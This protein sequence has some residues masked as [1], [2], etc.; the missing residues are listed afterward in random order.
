LLLKGHET[1]KKQLELIPLFNK[2][3]TE[4]ERGKRLQKDGSRIR[5]RSIKMY[6][7]VVRTLQEFSVSNQFPL[8]VLSG[9]NQGKRE[10]K[11]ERIYWKRFYLSYTNFLYQKGCFDNY[12]GTHIKIIRCFFNYLKLEK[13]IHT[14]EFHKSFYVRHETIPVVVLSPEQL[15]FLINDKGFEES[16]PNHLQR[17]K[18]LF[19][20]GCTVGL[21]FSD[22]MNLTARNLEYLAD[23]I[24][25]CVR[26]LKTS[27]ETRIKIPKY[28]IEILEKYK[29]KRSL[30]PKI[31]N[32][33]L[34]KNLKKLGEL[35][36]WVQEVN[37]FR[38]QR[39]VIKQLS[40]GQSHYRFCDLVT[41][42]TM[43][44]TAITMLLSMGVPELMVRKISG[45]SA[46]SLEFYRYV[47][48]AQMFVDTA[49]DMAFEKISRDKL[50]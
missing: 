1:T 44:R 3:I 21:R 49:T 36:G 4:S 40:K 17:T 23:N 6:H 32:A 18:D 34:N 29:R 26:S 25:L 16:L 50:L 41:T 45:H 5:I 47:E 43:R 48:Y 27:T 42:H 31:S 15:R 2:F 46:N 28:A 39:G 8:R 22:L 24:Y 14:G 30:F 38:E 7:I 11:S 13:G 9:F 35:A 33:R 37:K 19:V 20:F 10:I 12:V